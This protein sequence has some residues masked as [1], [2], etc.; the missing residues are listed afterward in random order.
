MS[1]KSL[2]STTPLTIGIA[3]LL[4]AVSVD[5]RTVTRE[6]ID[7]EGNRYEGDTVDG[8]IHGV[9]RFDW[10]DGSSY[11]G[12]FKNGEVHGEGTMLYVDGSKYTGTFIHGKRHGY[13]VLTVDNGDVY[14]GT[15]VADKLSG[16]GEWTSESNGE[17][18]QGLWKNGKR[19]GT[20]ILTREDGSRYSGFF[21]NNHRHG[22]GEIVNADGQT[23]RGYFRANLKHGDGI[24]EVDEQTKRFQSWQQ[25]ELVVDEEIREVENCALTV[26]DSP[27][28][29]VGDD[30]VDGLAHGTGR[31]VALDGSAYVNLGTFVL[32]SLVK[33]VV[34]PMTLPEEFDELR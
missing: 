2:W 14:V 7:E 28:M 10:V 9:G 20:G 31:A 4:L 13:G 3:T 25:G 12:D 24:L 23:Y 34:L 18:Y 30:C 8:E 6:I 5:A 27:W 29:F 19:H 1:L 33:G 32:G 16:E 11:E 22:F 21:L 26:E 17:S 15:F